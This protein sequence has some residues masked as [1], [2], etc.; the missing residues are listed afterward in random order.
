MKTFK[1]WRKFLHASQSGASGILVNVGLQNYIDFS[2][3]EA[4]RYCKME[5]SA[6]E[7]EA[8]LIREKSVELGALIKRVLRCLSEKR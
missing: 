5:I 1:P 6:L 2:A 3:E 8:D 4:A 7:E